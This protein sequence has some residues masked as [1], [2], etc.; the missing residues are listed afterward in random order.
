V[1]GRIDPH[2]RRSITF[3]NDTAFRPTRPAQDYARH[4]DLVLRRLR[5]IK[6]PDAVDLAMRGWALV[7]QEQQEPRTRENNN[8]AQ[9][10]FER[11]LKI[12][13]NE[14]DALAGG[15]YTYFLE[16]TRGWAT[17]GTD[18]EAKI[19]GQ[20]NRAIALAPGNVWAYYVRS[21]ML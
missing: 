2:L 4:D 16:Y 3:D 11:A 6:S 1:F 20:A 13:P 12:D 17:A 15:A 8:A 18:Y 19:L 5:L 14:R 7:W 10:L 9:A 21:P